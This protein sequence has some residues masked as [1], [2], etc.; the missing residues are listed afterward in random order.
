[1]TCEHVPDRFGESARE[2]DTSHRGAAVLANPGFGVSV[3]TA[4]H[5]CVRMDVITREGGAAWT[6]LLRSLVA[7]VE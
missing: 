5:G 6:S 4:I 2:L 1:M 3:P 7:R